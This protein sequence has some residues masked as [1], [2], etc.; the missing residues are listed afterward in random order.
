MP[1]DGGMLS[2][3]LVFT[4][5]GIFGSI[6][7]TGAAMAQDYN[8]QQPQ[9]GYKGKNGPE[10]WGTLSDK[11]K[12]CEEGMQQSPIDIVG[13]EDVRLDFV[14]ANYKGSP[15]TV[16]NTG[17]SLQVSGDGYLSTL[18]KRF[19]LQQFHFHSP[20]EH[21]TVGTVYDMEAH[22]VHRSLDGQIAVLAVF[23]RRGVENV[24]LK[25]ILR[26]VPNGPGEKVNVSDLKIN[27]YDLL[28][29][30]GQGYTYLGSLTTPPCTEGI[31]WYVLAE[32][33]EVSDAQI[34]TY[35]ALFGLNA[36]PTQPFNCRTVQLFPFVKGNGQFW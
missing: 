1:H 23:M 20:S 8:S 22:F 5:A 2:L 15:Y 7:I 34:S 28:P 4:V 21:T 32:P 19:E 9:W 18:G 3:R 33:V 16:V 31:T 30:T 10:R 27:P 26:H 35:R 25:N 17:S 24:V 12:L 6:I 14:R 36:R 11:F 13:A 29:P